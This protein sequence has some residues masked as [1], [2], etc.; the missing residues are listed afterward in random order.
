LQLWVLT[1]IRVRFQI[2]LLILAAAI[3]Q[4]PYTL[5]A[6]ELEEEGE[7]DGRFIRIE[8]SRDSLSRTVVDATQRFDSF[9]GDVRFEEETEGSR[10]RVRLGME[11]E[12]GEK[13]KPRLGLGLKLTL[14][15]LNNRVQ[16]VV[17]NLFEEDPPIL[18]EGRID[19]SFLG[20]D[21]NLEIAAATRVIIER[22]R[23]RALDFDVGI[24]LR[25]SEVQPFVKLRGKRLVYSDHVAFRWTQFFF[26]ESDDG[27]GTR[28]RFDLDLGIREQRLL[29]AT[30][31]ATLAEFSEGVDL[32][33]R[34]TWY[35]AFD[36]GK[37]AAGLAAY[38]HGH[39]EPGYV[40]SYGLAAVFRRPVWSDWLYL[41]VGNR[42]PSSHEKTTMTLR[43]SSK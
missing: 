33:Q 39:T 30:T 15:N 16:I 40:E 23:E 24:K 25:T 14:P 41:E 2:F 32:G 13:F 37:S 22:D 12:Q 18:K 42:K 10:V 6:S 27:F 43:R 35:R 7:E 31:L 38:A 21:D 5:S 20:T 3:L 26:W 34:F 36:R 28:R 9:F 19:S 11:W 1:Y 17:D 8:S 4:S 29:R